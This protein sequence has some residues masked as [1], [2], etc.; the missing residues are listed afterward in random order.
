MTFVAQYPTMAERL[1]HAPIVIGKVF[2]SAMGAALVIHNLYKLFD[3]LIRKIYRRRKQTPEIAE[4][5][6]H[7]TETAAVS[8][9]SE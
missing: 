4:N 9:A 8:A 5:H 1:T 6:I 3:W 2:L 7:E